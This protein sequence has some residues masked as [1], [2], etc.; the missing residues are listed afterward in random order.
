MDKANKDLAASSGSKATAQGGLSVTNKDL[1]ADSKTLADLHQLCLTKS[2]E[3]EAAVKSRDEELK[4]LAAAKKAISSQT[5]AADGIQYNLA[6]VSFVQ[7]QSGEDLAKLEAVRFVWDLAQKQASPA[8][9]QLASRMSTAMKSSRA[10]DDPFAKIKGLIADMIS[11]LESEADAD[12]SH[13]AYCDK[14]LSESN[15]KHA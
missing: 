14:E 9:A 11:R 2:Q 8:L 13:K 12:A 7:L 5:G 15:V 6:Q 4:A 1:A 3:Y 10:G